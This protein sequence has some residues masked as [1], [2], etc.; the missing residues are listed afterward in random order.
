MFNI[1]YIPGVFDLFH[2]GHVNLLEKS[3]EHCDALVIGV[4][5]DL[6]TKSYKKLP[7]DSENV[8]KQNID[9]FIREN[10]LEEKIIAVELV[11]GFHLEIIKK[12]NINMIFHGDDWEIESYKKQIR[13]YEDG[14]DKLNVE[15]V[16]LKYTIGISSTSIKLEKITNTFD[17]GKIDE[18]LFDLDNTLMLNGKAM[19]NAVKCIKFLQSK[20]IKIKV[21]TNN[22]KYTPKQISDILKINCIDLEES[23]IQSSL[24]QLLIFLRTNIDVYK[25][26]YIWGS[27]DA[28]DYL[29][30]NGIYIELEVNKSDII[31]FLYNENF[32]YME[33][34]NA[35]THISKNNIPYVVGNIDILYSNA[36]IILPDTG[37]VYK[38][39]QLTL[40]EQK[41]PLLILGKPSIDIYTPDNINKCIMV[42]DNI[43]TDGEYAKNM[44][45]P[46]IHLTEQRSL[47]NN[48]FKIF[49]IS[50]LGVVIDFF[51][52]LHI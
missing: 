18:V 47:L 40:G 31:I 35:L 28:K 2:H 49:Q 29:S 27:N 12:Y 39:V 17:F 6:F 15:I 32:T 48:N 25:K 19:Y 23:A 21:I 13:Y 34:S 43:K 16:I 33:L 14:L 36:N 10:K 9:N 8:R 37:I 24:K 3:L 26:P 46:F 44:N 52:F 5:T 11:G 50:H 4:H 30:Q 1:G 41:T 22:N 20:N 7:D 38:I 51:N 42:G 45:I